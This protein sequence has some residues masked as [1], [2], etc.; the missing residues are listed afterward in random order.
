M[1]V[2]VVDDEADFRGSLI[3]I[4]AIKGHEALG[5]GSV[6]EYFALYS[7]NTFDLVVIDRQLN[8]GNGLEILRHIRETRQV[9]AV[10]ITGSAEFKSADP[11]SEA[12][13]DLCIA[14]PFAVQPLLSFIEELESQAST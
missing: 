14:K 12:V 5:A 1:R 4:L 9:P 2:L 6:A 3:E 10:L 8:D 7:E 11:G 13:P